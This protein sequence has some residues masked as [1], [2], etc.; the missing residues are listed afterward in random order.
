MDNYKAPL[1]AVA[2]VRRFARDFENA[3]TD[4]GSRQ[5]DWAGDVSD[6]GNYANWHAAATKHAFPSDAFGAEAYAYLEEAGDSRD[7]AL[8]AELNGSVPGDSM[9][10]GEDFHDGMFNIFHADDDDDSW[11]AD[12][13]DSGEQGYY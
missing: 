9:F 7:A 11:D 6:V 3:V 12:E 2:K 4:A 8:L 5:A 1:A 13:W 10:S